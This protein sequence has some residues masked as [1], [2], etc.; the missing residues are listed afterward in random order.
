[1]ELVRRTSGVAARIVR[2]PGT[3]FEVHETRAFQRFY[4]VPAT[5]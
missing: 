1:M 5:P 4:E 2:Q 3:E